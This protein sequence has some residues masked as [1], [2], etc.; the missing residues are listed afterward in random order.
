MYVQ[1][2]TWQ[3]RLCGNGW[4]KGFEVG[5]LAWVAQVAQY[6]HEGLYQRKGSRSEGQSQRDTG[7]CYEDGGRG[8]MLR[9]AGGLEK[10]EEARK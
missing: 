6:N 5:R 8:H 4:V 10:L 9:N 2:P 3:K 7:K 1:V